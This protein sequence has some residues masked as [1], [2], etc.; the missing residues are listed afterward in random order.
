MISWEEVEHGEGKKMVPGLK[1]G[2]SSS[3]ASVSPQGQGPIAPQFSNFETIYSCCLSAPA[4]RLG[5][6]A[7]QAWADCGIL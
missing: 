1:T 2:A 3:R 4:D 6:G 5:K 7:L